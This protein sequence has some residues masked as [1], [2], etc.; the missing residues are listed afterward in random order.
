MIHDYPVL[1]DKDHKSCDKSTHYYD[2]TTNKCQSCASGRI[3]MSAQDTGGGHDSSACEVSPDLPVVESM[4]VAQVLIECG[5]DN[6]CEAPLVCDTKTNTCLK[7][8]GRTNGGRTP[9][10]YLN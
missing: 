10:Q 8:D 7:P 4:S 3:K 9:K 5:P 1:L 6:T 2:H